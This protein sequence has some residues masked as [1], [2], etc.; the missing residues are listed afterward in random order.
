MNLKLNS[1]KIEGI[2]L[3]LVEIVAE[4]NMTFQLF[5]FLPW[6]T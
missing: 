6:L 1:I 4:M 5:L 3:E 2:L